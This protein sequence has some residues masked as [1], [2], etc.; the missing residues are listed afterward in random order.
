MNT[1]QWAEIG[2]IAILLA[3]LFVI[4]HSTADITADFT[5][6]PTQGLAPLE[7]TFT[8]ASTGDVFEWNYDVDNDGDYD[9]T[10]RAQFGF[11]TTTYSS[12]TPNGVCQDSTYLYSVDVNEN[13]LIKQFLSNNSLVSE[14]GSYGTGDDQFYSPGGITTDGTYVYVADTYNNR[15][16]KRLCSDLSYVSKI[17]SYGT[18][19]DQ[20]DSPGGITTDGTYVYVA[21]TYNNRIV[22]RLCSDL[23]YVSKIGS[24]GSGDDQFYRPGGITTD[25][26]YVYV[27]D[28]HN[29]RI[30]KRLCSDLSYVSKI[31]SYGTG[32]DQFY[33][34]GGITTDNT[35]VYVADTENYRV[36]KR[37][38]S[39]LSYVS[40]IGSY[41]TGDDQFYRPGGITTDG[42]YVYVADTYNGR[43]V[44]RLCSDLSYVSL[45][46]G[47]E[48][49]DRSYYPS[50][51]TTDGTYVYVAD[52]NHNRIVKYFCNNLSYVSKIGSLSQGSG[53]DQF[54][55]PG[56]ITTDGTYVYVADTYNHR[57]VKRLCSDLSYVSKIGSQGSGDDQFYRPGGITTDGTY[58]YVA[59]TNNHRIVKRLCSDLSYVSKIGSQGSGDDQF[60]RPGGITTDGT[61]VYV[62]D[63]NNHRIVKRLCSDLSY[64]SKIGSQGS[65]D[66]QFYSP[67]GITTDNT[68]VYV[69]DT[70][71]HRVVKYFCNNLSYVSKIGSQ[72]SGNDQFYR[73]GGITTDGTY[74]YV[75]DTY[76]NRIV[77]RLYSDLSYY[78]PASP[79][80][81]YTL[82]GTYSVKQ[83][84]KG[85][86]I[87]EKLREDYI[88]VEAVTPSF[89][90][91]TKSGFRPLTVN[92]TDTSTGNPTS[93]CW[94]IDNDGDCDY[95]TQNCTHTYE[96][97]GK[98]SVNF[99]ATNE[100]GSNSDVK[101][102]YIN[103]VKQS[104]CPGVGVWDTYLIRSSPHVAY[105]IC[106]VYDLDDV[107]HLFY[108][109]GYLGTIDHT[110]VDGTTITTT[111]IH[112]GS[113]SGDH[114]QVDA[115]V[116]N[117]NKLHVVIKDDMEGDPAEYY[118]LTKT[119]T[120][121][122]SSPELIDTSSE[123]LL[124]EFEEARIAVSSTGQPWVI[125]REMWLDGDWYNRVAVYHKSGSEWIEEE[126]SIEYDAYCFSA[127][128]IILDNT[129]TPHVTY[130][131]RSG[132]DSWLYYGTRTGED[133]WSTAP[134]YEHANQYGTGSFTNL[135]FVNNTLNLL[136]ESGYTPFH[137]VYSGGSWSYEYLL[138]DVSAALSGTS[139]PSGAIWGVTADGDTAQKTQVAFKYPGE[140]WSD[141]EVIS[142]ISSY[143]AIDIVID[144]Q[145]NP[146]VV[147]PDSAYTH[148]YLLKYTQSPCGCVN[149]T[150][151]VYYYNGTL[152]E[153]GVDVIVLDGEGDYWY[154]T[155]NSS[156]SYALNE[157][158]RNLELSI[159]P[160][161]D[162]YS[163]TPI[164][165][166]PDS[167]GEYYADLVLVPD[168]PG[169][170]TTT[171]G[172]FVYQKPFYELDD[173]I[174][175]E[176]TNGSWSNSTTTNSAGYYV[177][178]DGLCGG[179]VY[180]VSCEVEDHTPHSEDVTAVEMVF[181]Q[182][183]FYLDESFTLTVYVKDLSTE[184]FL[185][186]RNVTVS[187]ST[188]AEYNT[189]TGIAVFGGLSYGVVDITTGAIDYYPGGGSVVMDSSK[190]T[191]IFMQVK[192]EPSD[193]SAPIYAGHQVR[194]VVQRLW[195]EPIPYVNV[196]ATTIESSAP[197][198]W[199]YNILGM[200]VTPS[201]QNTTLTGMTGSDGS[202]TSM[203]VESVRYDMSFVNVSQGVNEHITIWPKEDNYVIVAIG[204]PQTYSFD[205]YDCTFGCEAVN[206]TH[207]NISC[208]YLDPMGT[209]TG[210]TFYCKNSSG[211]LLY[212]ST[213]GACSSF[214][215]NCHLEKA[216]GD[217][218]T[219]GLTTS[220][221]GSETNLTWDQYISFPEE[222]EKLVTWNAYGITVPDIA[223]DWAGIALIIC[224]GALASKTIVRYVGIFMTIFAD[225]WMLLGWFPTTVSA[226]SD[227]YGPE[228]ALVFMWTF[229]ATATFIAIFF[230]MRKGAQEEFVA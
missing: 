104:N 139:G 101:P 77:K 179:E 176:I 87:D 158:V 97:L 27:A 117:Y 48:D 159:W 152:V 164:N 223:Y 84:L 200:N 92:F 70:N 130:T 113:S 22:K 150:G 4:G 88:Q 227:R 61:Y 143:G 122:W 102:N 99:T 217:Y 133:S 192:P 204:S 180:T 3:V 165:F 168:D 58:V 46:W 136:F 66:D 186:D 163:S 193:T 172:G 25:G 149:I 79:T 140:P 9:I 188:G 170:N 19:D 16:V 144:S 224:I 124:S 226:L 197:W 203:M 51:I 190:S 31:G 220:H 184:A 32:D 191:T 89:T 49:G 171:I 54:Y 90:T 154:T 116:D 59:D 115:V 91:D 98:Y 194:F 44:K 94:D 112:T 110:K 34:P 118:Y 5:A 24:Q 155:T 95:T 185:D 131:Y 40:K 69:A 156:G 160:E 67:G 53:D 225:L 162:G 76:N 128:S 33:S 65:G 147:T 135:F 167:C 205:N 1:K 63:T 80:W 216:P 43:I 106:A 145:D 13:R 173:G 6:N 105:Q 28:I 18:G 166:T 213:S 29:N 177:F 202:W 215:A 109:D 119:P 210:C 138:P 206:S 121:A 71:N 189:A 74:V 207:Y 82:P 134:I 17:G 195:G 125:I 15:I 219:Y 107:L 62:A 75:A 218:Y 68:Y 126:I 178:T 2:I 198:D 146:A 37:L 221:A 57:I 60:Y 108:W 127:C 148:L 196:T 14:I 114:L 183:D 26:T 222:G 11:Q 55:R 86:T 182:Q 208:S 209:T 137:G 141:F 73:P 169:Y 153:D 41:G 81:E 45:V 21:D 10:D 151:D 52:T 111:T 72:G 36:V 93:W 38:C 174:T 201:V 50:G 83:F 212:T 20:F 64:V 142:S 228:L 181:T 157:L 132:T 47:L 103:V 85:L 161:K 30:V 229:F 39:D 129:N 123:D 96:N 7:V 78:T 120:S 199:I 211:D 42:T 56:G 230:Y 23:S 12:Q 214:N 175:V 35:Y 187:L 100:Y 8:D